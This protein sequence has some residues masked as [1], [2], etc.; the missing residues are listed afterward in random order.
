MKRRSLFRS[1]AVATGI[2][3]LLIALFADT[4]GF[5]RGNGLGHVQLFSIILGLSLIYLTIRHES[6]SDRFGSLS[7]IVT[8]TIMIL[9]VLELASTFTLR[10]F[11]E[12]IPHPDTREPSEVQRILFKRDFGERLFLTWIY[13]PYVLHRTVP[14]VS[15]DLLST[16][17][18]G[19]RITPG[20]EAGTD[21]HGFL[22]YC[23]GG[24]T[25][26]GWG[27]ADDQTIPAH[28]QAL[29]SN[30]LDCPVEVRNMGQPSWLSTQELIQLILVLWEGERPDLVV[31]YDGA[32]DLLAASSGRCG[33]HLITQHI[34]NVLS[35]RPSGE[36][37]G[38]N[39][40]WEVLRSTNT[41]GLLT[42][43]SGNTEE[44]RLV[45]FPTMNQTEMSS[46]IMDSLADAVLNCALGNYRIALSLG[47]GFGFDCLFLWH[48]LL[49]VTDKPLTETEKLIRQDAM[50][51]SVGSEQI[52][53]TWSLASELS[54]GG[55]VPG[56]TDISGA[57]DDCTLQC[58]ID[59]C[60]L[61]GTGNRIV[62][63]SMFVRILQLNLSAMTPFKETPND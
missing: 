57:L 42:G 28:L 12:K 25:I 36:T 31:F 38:H 1:I 59:P 2:V 52:R 37:T 39:L 32:N 7:I 54:T 60:H 62:A 22:V 10:L 61:N 3:L 56:F 48:P 18:D 19:F 9:L 44:N 17:T 14:G 43:L 16:D 5:G 55:V 23:F 26:W 41:V 8:N 4:V 47:S 27:E 40:L 45:Q 34:E 13:K 20:V 33:S 46:T 49:V 30:H 51:D 58:Y 6:I 11:A 15:T 29:L 24:S 63:E 50:S 35:Y 53:R 21:E